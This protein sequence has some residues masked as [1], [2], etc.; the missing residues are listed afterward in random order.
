MPGLSKRQQNAWRRAWASRLFTFVA[1]HGNGIYTVPSQTD[2][3][4]WYAVTRYRLAPDGYIWICDCEAS[5]RGG[6]VCTHAMAAYLWRLKNVMG[7][8]LKYPEDGGG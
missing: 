6:V 5:Q 4:K 2:A 3:D 8:R 1:Y 7:Y